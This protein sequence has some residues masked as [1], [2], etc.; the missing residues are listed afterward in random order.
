MNERAQKEAMEIIDEIVQ[1][2]NLKK[3]K[4]TLHEFHVFYN[5]VYDLRKRGETYV[6][7]ENV[8]ELLVKCGFADSENGVGWK[9]IE[10]GGKE[11][12]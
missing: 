5:C 11:D 6:I 4:L 8:K 3:Y 1:N 9:I 10:N 12:E 2:G 7:E